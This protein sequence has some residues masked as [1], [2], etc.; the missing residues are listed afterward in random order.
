VQLCTR[1][2]RAEVW[3][4]DETRKL[5]RIT[6]RRALPGT[7]EGPVAIAHGRLVVLGADHQRLHEEILAASIRLD[8]PRG[9]RS[10]LNVGDTEKA[11]AAQ[12]NEALASVAVEPWRASWDRLAEDLLRALEDRA[13]SRTKSLARAFE[14]RSEREATAVRALLTELAARIRET[15][16]DRDDTPMLPGFAQDELMQKDRDRASLRERLERIPAEIT[17][18]A[19][20][21]RARYAEVSPRLF[22][23]AVT[24]LL[25]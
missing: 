15:L 3:S 6:A 10:R 16:D 4:R 1:L 18:E 22:P 8:G 12:G 21:I 19:G 25:P 5:H 11:L 13:E 14:D 9:V 2:L 23:L 24:L 20:A 7:L 17:R